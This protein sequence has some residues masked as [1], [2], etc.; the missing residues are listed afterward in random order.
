MIRDFYYG[1]GVGDLFAIFLCTLDR[2]N[3]PLTSTCGSSWVI[4]RPRILSPTTARIRKK[5]LR[6]TS[7][8]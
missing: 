3:P 6:V 1:A 2:P 7:G 4:C 8:R 5:L